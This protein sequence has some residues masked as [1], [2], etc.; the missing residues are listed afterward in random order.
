MEREWIETE[1][2][3]DILRPQTEEERAY[4]SEQVKVGWVEGFKQAD[5]VFEEDLNR[6]MSDFQGMVRYRMLLAQRMISQ[7]Y[8]LQ[9]DRGVTGDGTVMRVGD[10]AVQITGVPK[11]LTGSDKWRPVNR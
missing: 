1:P 4:W 2:P 9:T 7:P 8:A 5:E 11:L 3:P 10:R 6:L